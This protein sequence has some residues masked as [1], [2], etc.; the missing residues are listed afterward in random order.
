M[1]ETSKLLAEFAKLLNA[2]GEE[3]IEVQNFLKLY[4]NNTELVE[5]A[6]MAI[7]VKQALSQ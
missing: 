7:R 2:Y 3:S 4:E 6:K 1:E 5:L